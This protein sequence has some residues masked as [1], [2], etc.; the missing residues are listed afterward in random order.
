MSPFENLSVGFAGGLALACLFR[1]SARKLGFVS[2]VS[3]SVTNDDRCAAAIVRELNRARREILVPAQLFSCQPIAA[4]LIAAIERGVTVHLLLRDSV[5][6]ARCPDGG[7]PESRCLKS[8]IETHA[9]MGNGKVILLIDR[10]TIVSG[11]IHFDSGLKSEGGS[12]LVI[13]G[14]PDLA[15]AWANQFLADP[16][17]DSEPPRMLEN[18]G[19]R[20]AA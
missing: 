9:D 11:R 4:E 14:R 12:L 18:E 5:K 17:Q 19:D 10:R 16:G 6:T 13:K 15:A 1:W 7:L 2:H 20:Q 8:L 3:V